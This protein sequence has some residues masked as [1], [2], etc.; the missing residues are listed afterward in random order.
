MRQTVTPYLLYED[1]S[2]AV[3]FLTEA[4]GFREVDRMTGRGGGMHVEMEVGADRGRI[5]L[6]AP[7]GDFRGPATVGRT[8][9]VYVL[10][11]DVDRHY[12]QAKAAGATITEELIEFEYDRR[13]GCRDPQGHGWTFATPTAAGAETTAP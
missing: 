6:G 7:G 2:A 9:L 4:F 5:Y 10:V 1:A 3:A 13:Y 8:S 11:E 12:E